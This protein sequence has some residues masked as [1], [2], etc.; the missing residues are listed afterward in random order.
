MNILLT[1]GTGYIGSHAASVLAMA[2][3]RCVLYDN[4]SNS[5]ENVVRLLHEITGQ[6]MIF[7]RG[8]I[9]D[10]N[11]LAETLRT[12]GIEAVLHF[13]GLKSL[14][15]SLEKPTEYYSNNVQGTLALVQ[16]M[17]A[18]NVKTL[19]FSSS[20]A[21][22]GTPRHLPITEEHVTAPENPYGRSKRYIETMLQDVAAA[23]ANWR[24]AS[25][26]YFN[27]I[28][29]HDSGRIGEMSLVPPNNIMP[30]IIAVASGAR[31][32]LQVFGND[33]DTKDG[34]GI[35]DYIHVMDLA[36]GHLAALN[37]LYTKTSACDIV[38]LGTGKGYSVLEIIKTFE[39]ATGA[40]VR[41]DISPRRAGD[42]ASCYANV[43][44]AKKLLGWTATRSLADMCKSA[45]NFS[46]RDSTVAKKLKAQ[47]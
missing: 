15:E 11:L 7:I 36:E 27:P 5:S 24:I 40:R 30:G 39:T 25:L 6:R 23:D 17:Q 16:A 4:L 28:G 9:R 42:V 47:P 45:W 18:A 21:V 35:R 41:Y 12:H 8:D 32:A 38:N 1:G 13:A 2:G 37:Y 22:Y 46:M 34:T 20:A 31:A 44:K 3:H 14:P 43:E 10:T 33:Y 29:A 19:V 26:R